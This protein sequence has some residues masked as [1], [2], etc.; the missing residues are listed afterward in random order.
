MKVAI[1]G[2]KGFLGKNIKEKSDIHFQR[3]DISPEDGINYVDIKDAESLDVLKGFDAIINL[4]AEH[5]DNVLPKSKYYETNVAGSK[6]ICEAARKFDINKIIFVSS[7][8]V[9]GFADPFIAEDGKINPFND[10][11][12]SKWEAEKVY[13]E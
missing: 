3:F 1:I 12:K 6:N 7:V 4:A 2:A 5:K 8:A 13:N 9:Y 11:G 10:Y